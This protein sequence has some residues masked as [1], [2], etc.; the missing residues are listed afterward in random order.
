MQ[1][2]PAMIAAT[3]ASGASGAWPVIALASLVLWSVTVIGLVLAMRRGRRQSGPRPC[4]DDLERIIDRLPVGVLVM[5]PISRTVIDANPRACELLGPE[6]TAPGA[7]DCNRLNDGQAPPHCPALNGNEDLC[8]GECVVHQ[9]DGSERVID[10]RV[11]PIHLHGRLLLLETFIDLTAARRAESELRATTAKLEQALAY[12]EATARRA[13]EGNAAKNEFVAHVTHELRTPLNGIVGMA[14]LLRD[15]PLNEEQQEYVRIVRSCSKGLATLVNDLL[16]FSRI[17]AQRLEI[18]S[19]TFSLRDLLDDIHR[20]MAPRATEAGLDLSLHI[21]QIVPQEL[22]G[23]PARLRQ[24]L[25]NLVDNAIKFTEQGSV[26]IR[27]RLVLEEAGQNV[28]RFEVRDTGIG[29]DPALSDQLFEPFRQAPTA[30]HTAGT[31]LGL[32]ICRRLVE[33]Q[34]GEI[35]IL[36]EQAQ[37]SCFWFQLAFGQPTASEPDSPGTTSRG[38][39]AVRPHHGGQ[40]RVLL[41]EDNDMNRKVVGL[42]LERLGC[43]VET[44]ADGAAAIDRLRH[45][46]FDVVLMDCLMPTL[47]GL[48][49]TRRIRNPEWGARDPAVPIVG[50]SAHTL[51]ADR[52]RAIGAGMDAYLAKPVRS[53]DLTRILDNLL[54]RAHAAVATETS[55]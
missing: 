18:E 21:A 24:V 37:G 13:D 8:T 41:A 31:G 40:P 15:T 17:E 28:L 14:S 36:T 22:R 43:R 26:N 38:Q 33:L 35:G 19:I 29:V 25:V 47:D 9:N 34:G 54:R 39:L 20:L 30:N 55:P 48:E 51:L 6:L 44:V 16:D 4:A 49:A 11:V 2:I 27:V 1:F 7:C 12:A 42:L 3:Y 45:Q 5:D 52:D 32:A 50:L 23:D 46:D 10:K 53:A